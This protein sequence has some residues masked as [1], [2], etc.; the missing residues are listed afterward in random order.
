MRKT[1]RI[2]QLEDKYL[3]SAIDC[4]LTSQMENGNLQYDL[5]MSKEEIEVGIFN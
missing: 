4:L 3:S 5:M 2:V 1:I